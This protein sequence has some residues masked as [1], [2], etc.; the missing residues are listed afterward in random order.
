MHMDPITSSKTMNMATGLGTTTAFDLQPPRQGIGVNTFHS[1]Q[2]QALVPAME[3]MFGKKRMAKERIYWCFSPEK[4]PRVVALLKW[5]DA[6]SDGLA[7]I[8]LQHFLQTGQR[9]AFITN[10]EY[11]VPGPNPQPAFDWITKNHLRA[12]LDR[13]FQESVVTYDPAKI[14]IVFVFLL[15]AS[16]N[17]MVCWRR[18][19]PVSEELRMRYRR[20][21]EKTL[22]RLEEKKQVIVDELPPPPPKPEEPPP[23]PKKKRGFWRRLFGI[24]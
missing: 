8:G 12:T 15:S 11:M 3:A 19:L 5:I 10:V 22:G 4:D 16:K 24:K 6:M 13:V 20:D 21:I 9:G 17:S 7:T 18:K 23:P 1:S 14:V 2:G